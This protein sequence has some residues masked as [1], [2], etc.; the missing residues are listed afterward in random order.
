MHNHLYLFGSNKMKRKS[1]VFRILLLFS[2]ISITL[3]TGCSG[4]RKLGYLEDKYDT[5]GRKY[6]KFHRVAEADHALGLKYPGFLV[7]IEKGDRKKIDPS[8]MHNINNLL[9]EATTPEKN[10]ARVKGIMGDRKITFVSHI[11]EYRLKSVKSEKPYSGIPYIEEDFIHNAYEKNFNQLNLYTYS[12]KALDDLDKRIKV[13]TE[14]LITM[15]N[16]FNWDALLHEIRRGANNLPIKLLTSKLNVNQLDSINTAKMNQISE[17]VKEDIVRAFNNIKNNLAFY[18]DEVAD[19]GIKLSLDVLTELKGLK[20]I[21][22]KKV[23][24]QILKKRTLNGSILL[25]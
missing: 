24:C 7:G 6:A 9:S 25:S 15:D 14:P 10:L 5:E 2:L 17:I 1:V 22:V 3:L 13:I 8:N 20:E 18:N 12:S 19:K 21:L 4:P 16:I 11:V 23:I